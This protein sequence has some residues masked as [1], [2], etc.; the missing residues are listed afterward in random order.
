MT[1][2]ETVKGLKLFNDGVKNIRAKVCP[3]GFK[4][5]RIY[6]RK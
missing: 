6:R 5:G 1:N 2:E 3:D 4:P